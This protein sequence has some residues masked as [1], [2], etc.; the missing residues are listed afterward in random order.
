MNFPGDKSFLG[1][2]CGPIID[3]GP[4]ITA[5]ILRK[6]GQQ[7]H[8]ST[9]RVLTPD[10]LL[11]TDEIKAR[12]EFYTAIRDMVGPAASAKYFKSEQDI[13][14]LLLIGM[15]MVRRIKLTCVRWMKLRLRQ[16]KIILGQR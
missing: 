14:T 8:R 15:R 7:F 9:Y 5:N 11:N 12:D 10:E 2:Y 13:I 4:A 1:S 3:V 16:W 6:N